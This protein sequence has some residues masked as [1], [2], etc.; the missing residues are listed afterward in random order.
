MRIDS[1][2]V[3]VLFSLC[4]HTACGDDDDYGCS[5]D[6]IDGFFSEDMQIEIQATSVDSIVNYIETEGENIVF[7]LN[8]NGAQCDDVFDD[9]WGQDLTFEI[10]SNL[11]AFHFI[12][13]EL[14]GLLCHYRQFGTWVS[15]RN[16]LVESGFV[17]GT[18]ID[19]T[20]WDVE[21]DVNL[22]V[23][24]SRDEDTFR[25]EGIFELL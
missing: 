15:S 7:T 11:N 10:E 19:A 13:Q 18:R 1:I 17:K 3:L 16:Y 14:L 21:V 4:I 2:V 20:M 9:E 23:S 5:D 24:N 22:P 25:W 12:D 8:H 6:T